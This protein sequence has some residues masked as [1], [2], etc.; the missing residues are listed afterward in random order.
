M[1]GDSDDFCSVE[2]ESP[3]VESPVEP[4]P[5]KINAEMERNDRA[6]SEEGFFIE[7]YNKVVVAERRGK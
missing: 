7:R 4:Q 2:L 6:R 5:R 1:E 3:S